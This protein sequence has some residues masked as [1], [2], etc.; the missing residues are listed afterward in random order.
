METLIPEFPKGLS[1]MWPDP[2]EALAVLQNGA[3]TDPL[4]AMPAALRNSR[5]D[6]VF[7]LTVTVDYPFIDFCSDIV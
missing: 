6:H 4:P 1:G 3:I 2:S 5:R 7:F